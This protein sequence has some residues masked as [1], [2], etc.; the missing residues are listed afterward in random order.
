MGME[1]YHFS[2]RAM[3]SGL[4]QGW[5]HWEVQ[6]VKCVG[7]LRARDSWTEHGEGR[8]EAETVAM[9]GCSY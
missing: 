3:K 7:Q 6:E 9:V 5:W 2:A 8:R 4:V 1:H